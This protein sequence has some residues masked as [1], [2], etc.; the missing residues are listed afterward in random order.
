MPSENLLRLETSPYLLQHADNPVHWTGWN[1]AALDEAQT[2]GLPILLSIGYA[3][4]H[5]CHVMA[6]ESF[7]DEEVAAVMN[8][9]FVCVKVDREERPDIDDIYMTALSMMGEQ[10]GWPLTMFLDHSGRPFWGGTYF[11]KEPAYGRPGFIQLLTQISGAYQ[12]GDPQIETNMRAL[13][14]GLTA[15]AT[16]DAAG[17][18]PGDLPGR[19][20]RSIAAHIDE[21]HGGMGGAPQFPQPVLYRFLLDQAHIE[22]DGGASSRVLHTLT[23]IC[24]GG[25][26][27]HLGGGFSRY[28]VDAEW[29]IPHFEKM[30]Y[31]NGLLL[32]WMAQAWRITK[33]PLYARRMEETVA[34][35]QRDMLLEPGYFA[36]S[37]DADSEGEEGKYYIWS[38]DELGQ[39][40]GDDR[41]A[42]AAAYRCSPNGNFEGN[43][44]PNRLGQDDADSDHLEDLRAQL[45]TARARRIPPG[46]DDKVLADWNG[47]LIAGLC[48][49]ATVMDRADWLAMAERAFAGIVSDLSDG[50]GLVHSMR[51]NS[52]MPLGLGEDLVLMSDAAL[53][54]YSATG[55]PD[56]L[57]HAETWMTHLEAAYACRGGYSSAATAQRDVLVHNRPVFDNAV[58]S[59]NGS[60]LLVLAK[61]A[62]LTGAPAY[63]E[64]AA[65]LRRNFS[66]LLPRSYIQMP[67]FLG[68]ARLL[69]HATTAVIITDDFND[70][71]YRALYRLLAEACGPDLLIIPSRDKAATLAKL[72]P[73]FGKTRLD[74]KP[75]VYLCPAGSCLPPINTI[76]ALKEQLS[77][78]N[79]SSS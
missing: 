78:L 35:L 43:N 5:W 70:P 29:L 4:C 64:R 72:H 46:Q 7:E 9:N 39:I 23:Q 8:D 16:R 20:L 56:Y 58:P 33:N 1:Q 27:D 48:E 36:A 34:W 74:S 55:R 44:I 40:L 37:L 14:D 32:G 3:A 79:L 41:E 25:I 73:A 31:D 12:K 15:Q 59:L 2:R 69:D 66:G 13:K 45:L 52:R 62:H 17:D 63:Y 11:P 47:L 28:T 57:G 18:Y 68:A 76:Q 19:A 10:G 30:L 49:A 22:K 65:N 50:D 53:H 54:L 6:H 61:L 77:R 38:W 24:Q 26:Y 71:D 51:G 75:T 21:G 42:F 67:R 60:A